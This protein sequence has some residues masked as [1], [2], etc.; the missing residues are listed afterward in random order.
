M[1]K[2]P[3]NKA[4]HLQRKKKHVGQLKRR[5]FQIA[6]EHNRKPSSSLNAQNDNCGF[7]S[8]T[9]TR[10]QRR[11]MYLSRRAQRMKI[12]EVSC[13][14]SNNAAHV[15]YQQEKCDPADYSPIKPVFLADYMTDEFLFNVITIR[16]FRQVC[17]KA[18]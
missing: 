3:E 10:E 13:K 1:P 15:I 6:F 17:K 7:F 14:L 2:E 4:K 18:N 5:P 12:E 11:A 16:R 9:Y 8:P